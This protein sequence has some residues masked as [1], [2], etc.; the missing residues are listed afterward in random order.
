[1]GFQRVGGGSEP[2]PPGE[3]PLDTA[4]FFLDRAFMDQ[5]SGLPSSSS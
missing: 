1:M 3:G 2:G 5:V 4:L